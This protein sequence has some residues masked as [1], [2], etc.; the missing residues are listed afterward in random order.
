MRKGKSKKR[1]KLTASNAD[2]HILYE[3]SVQSVDSNLEFMTQTFRE[4]TGRELQSLTE[5]FC[6]TACLSCAWVESGDE[7]VALGI[8]L[9]PE[10]LAWCRE[11]HIPSLSAPERLTLVEGN[12]LDAREQKVDLIAA[13]NFSYFIFYDRDSLRRYFE[14]ARTGLK[15]DGMLMLDVFG[16][17]TTFDVAL[18]EQYVEPFK[19]YDGVKYGGYFYQWEQAEFNVITNRIKCHIHFGF[20]DDSSMKE[21]F[22][23]EWRM[24][25]V[26]EITEVL[27]EAG[28]ETTDVFIHGWDEDGDADDDF[29]KREVYDNEAGWIG[30]IVAK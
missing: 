22:T 7:R 21:A 25:T 26:P 13:F 19:R 16:G 28:F 10:P 5:D 23:Y 11:N 9:D 8:D 27:R 14:V 30:F 12:V 1:I 2:K 24:W 3:Q 15:E 18:E 4:Y 29:Q 17:T 6:G 20:E